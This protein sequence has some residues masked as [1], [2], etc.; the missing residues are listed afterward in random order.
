MLTASLAGGS[1]TSTIDFG[2]FSTVSKTGLVN[3]YSTGPFSLQIASTNNGV[4]KLQGSPVDSA[5][6]AVSYSINFNGTPIAVG[7]TARF[8]RTGIG[9]AGLPLQ[10][11]TEQPTAKRAGTYR[12]S[13]T[14]TFTPLATL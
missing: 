14:L 8:A 10:I 4:M 5:N 9:G 13:L 2:D 6:A 11:T 7:D 3:V 12:D 1:T